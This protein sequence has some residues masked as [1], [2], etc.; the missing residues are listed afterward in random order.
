MKEVVWGGTKIDKLFGENIEEIKSTLLAFAHK[1]TG[2][3]HDAQDL[4]QETVLRVLTNKDKFTAWTNF[5]AWVV[6][7]MRNVF[8]NDFRKKQRRWQV[9]DTTWWYLLEWLLNKVLPRWDWQILHDEL[10]RIVS[11]LDHKY[12]IPFELSFQWYKYEEIA[13]ELDLPLG[14]IKSRIFFARIKLKRMIER[15]YP[16]GVRNDY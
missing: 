6:T 9:I 11:D 5:K 10:K 14:T 15:R 3:Y 8:I 16:D 4:Y 12:R 13:A 7:I 1:L 2:D